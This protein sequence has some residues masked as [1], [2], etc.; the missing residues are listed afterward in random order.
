MAEDTKVNTK[1]MNNKFTEI[2][3]ESVKKVKINKKKSKITTNKKISKKIKSYKK[4]I[5]FDDEGIELMPDDSRVINI[6]LKKIDDAYNDF[7]IKTKDTISPALLSYC[8]KYSRKV[9][10]KHK[11]TIKIDTPGAQH[12][13]EELKNCFKNQF[14]SSLKKQKQLLSYNLYSSIVLFLMGLIIISAS[15][16]LTFFISSDFFI[17]TIM[18][19]GTFFVWQASDFYFIKRKEVKYRY[20]RSI[21]LYE[22]KILFENNENI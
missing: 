21:N 13:K 7:N 16:A 2:N 10:I 19:F 6:S 20:T 12:E 15:F 4:V 11:L 17:N 5:T 22:S 8:E 9:D 14:M 3:N 1:K 18:I